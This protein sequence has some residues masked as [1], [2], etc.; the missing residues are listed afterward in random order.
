MAGLWDAPSVNFF[1]TTLNGNINSSVDTITLNSVTGLNAPGVL[2]INREDGNGTATPSAREVISFTGISGSDLTG[3]TRGY[4]G[5]TAR[6]HSSGALV[7]AT[8]TVGMWNDAVA[9]LTNV[10]VAGTGAVDTTKV[11]TLTGTQTLTDKTLTTPAINTPTIA[12]PVIN[13]AVTGTITL[14]L[15]AYASGFNPSEGFLINGKI[16]PS[17]GSN[18][19]TVAIKGMDGNDPSASNPVYIRIGDTIRAITAALSVT[20]NAGTNWCNA[21]STELA[22]KEIDYFVYIGYNATDGVVVGFS[23]IP[24][25]TIYSDFSATTTNEKYAGISTIS[26]AA[27]GDNYRVIGRFA[28]TLSAGAGYTWTVPSFTGINLIQRPVFES[29]WLDYV[30]AITPGGSLT[31]GSQT[32]DYAR[33]KLHN[34]S[35]VMR[36][37]QFGTM[38]GS[39][40]ALISISGP[41]APISVNGT[42]ANKASFFASAWIAGNAVW[43]GAL[44]QLNRYDNSNHPTSGTYYF[45]SALE[46]QI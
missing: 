33:Y 11:V 26:N 9:A 10:V 18:N 42:E 46:Y 12:T 45:S 21:G 24:H 7:E 44:V 1:S 5:S 41:F 43:V 4:D 37:R 16:V 38:G 3:C 14:P 6:A 2:I 39:G 19:L 20:K 35:L 31:I 22:T 32:T 36:T 30:P 23:R 8:F 25:A 13:G 28:A 27:A 34:D 29:R 40:N 15:T 17:V